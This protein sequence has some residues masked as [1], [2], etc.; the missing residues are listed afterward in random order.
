VATGYNNEYMDCGDCTPVYF[1]AYSGFSISDACNNTTSMR[2]YYR[3]SL[4]QN[5][6]TIL[7]TNSGLTQTVDFGYYRNNDDLIFGVL[8][9]LQYPSEDPGMINFE[10]GPCPTPTPTP[11]PT[12]LFT[13]YVSDGSAQQACDGGTF[14]PLSPVPPYEQTPF[15]AFAFDIIGATGDLCN[16]TLISTSGY[17]G[18]G[19][20]IKPMAQGGTYDMNPEFWI[21]SGGFVRK[22]SRVGTTSNATPLDTCVSCTGGPTPTPLPPTSTPTPL[23]TVSVG[24]PIFVGYGSTCQD[25][26]G[27]SATTSIY[28][29]STD[30]QSLNSGQTYYDGGG[31]I[32]N[33]EGLYYSDMSNYCGIINSNGILGSMGTCN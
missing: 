18:N 15:Y 23:P 7:Y 26:C 5:F 13:G 22:W 21:A 24:D 14:G 10:G 2:V 33:G 19:D 31:N 8:N 4:G 11:L 12:G 25:A 20:I 3:G 32:L 6:D 28:A 17:S 27:G 16:A 9:T 30:P 1:D 29:K